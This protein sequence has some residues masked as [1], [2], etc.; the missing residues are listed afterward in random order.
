MMKRIVRSFVVLLCPALLAACPSA[1]GL[2]GLRILKT[3]LKTAGYDLVYPLTT[4]Y[5]VGLLFQI[6]ETTDGTMFRKTL[7]TVTYD[8]SEGVQENLLL[9]TY[10]SDKTSNF[11]ILAGLSETLLKGKAEA[12]ATLKNNDVSKVSLTL[13]NVVG[14]QLPPK[15]L[16]DG[17]RRSV[18]P[19]CKLNIKSAVDA[20]G[21]FTRPTVLVVGTATT[22][23]LNYTFVVE[24]ETEAK[25]TLLI[26]ALFK[27][28]PQFKT[29]EN[30][31]KTIIVSP[32]DGKHYVV[33]G[34][35]IPISK[36]EVLSEVTTDFDV[37]FEEDKNSKIDLATV[38][39]LPDGR[40]K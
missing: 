21:R 33:G 5:N 23:S 22:D 30:G 31:K 15:W 25:L 26:K 13:S 7:C 19:E 2:Q 36:A 29:T 14:E 8:N 24:E 3:E 28:E 38:F 18:N 40:P 37:A 39:Q 17:T 34:Q 11:E 20:E 6:R 12:N 27:V 16:P 32:K 10:E 4:G 9:S 35:A 1:E